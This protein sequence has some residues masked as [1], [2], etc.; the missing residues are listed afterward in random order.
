M[1]RFANTTG[2]CRSL[3]WNFRDFPIDLSKI[4]GPSAA[5]LNVTEMLNVHR[6]QHSHLLMWSCSEQLKKGLD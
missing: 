6:R 2:A 4:L 5:P 1:S 3:G